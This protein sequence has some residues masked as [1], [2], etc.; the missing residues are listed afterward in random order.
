M[1]AC[2]RMCVR[3]YACMSTMPHLCSYRMELWPLS[4]QHSCV[5]TGLGVHG[6]SCRLWDNNLLAAPPSS[7]LPLLMGV[8]IAP[9][10][11][12]TS[13]LPP[14]LHLA[15]PIALRWT[16]R[17]SERAAAAPRPVGIFPLEATIGGSVCWI[18][19]SCAQYYPISCDSLTE[20]MR[21][22]WRRK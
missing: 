14:P 15:A 12:T 6:S 2:M 16:P 22:L 17:A 8:T 21:R 10:P 3:V 19:Q 18:S 11:H 1:H 4:H 13:T 7:L 20:E 5:A 9:S